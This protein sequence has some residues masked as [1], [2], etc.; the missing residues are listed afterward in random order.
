MLK[1]DLDDAAIAGFK[2]ENH[3]GYAGSVIYGCHEL[4]I[5]LIAHLDVVSAG[6]G[7]IY[8]PFKPVIKENFIIARGSADDKSAA[9]GNLYLLRMFRDL[10]VPLHHNL[11]AVYGMAEENGMSDM[12]WY[13]KNF[14]MPLL[15]LVTDGNFPVNNAQKGQLNIK[16]QINTDGV[17]STLIAG[18]YPNNVPDSAKITITGDSTRKVINPDIRSCAEE[19]KIHMHAK[20]ISGHAAFPEGT[21]NAVTVLLQELIQGNWLTANEQRLAS[22]LYRIFGS[23]WPE[24]TRLTMED[25]ISGKLTL[26]AGVW[27]PGEKDNTL[28][29][30]IDIRYPVSLK[31]EDVLSAFSSEIADLEATIEVVKAFSRYYMDGNDARVTLLMDTYN[32]RMNTC[33]LPYSMGGGTHSRVLPDAI[34]FG[35]NFVHGHAPDFLPT[36]HGFPHGPDE[37]QYLPAIKAFLK[38]YFQ[39]ILRIDKKLYEQRSERQASQS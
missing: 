26:N 36:G 19:G 29:I 30:D 34:T 14:R 8:E 7:W 1:R 22:E 37:A 12:Q 13:A 16:I 17:L 25:A 5:G 6:P 21:L 2:T 27:R 15:S 39:A 24:N 31:S 4:D 18:N 33:E 23:S 38:I 3:A 10:A 32:E 20:G 35:P 11:R 9:L 28:S